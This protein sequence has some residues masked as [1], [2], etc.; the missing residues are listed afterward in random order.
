[1]RSAVVLAG[2]QSKRFQDGSGRWVDK[3]LAILSGKPLLMHVIEGVRPVV[4]E[5]IIC[6]NDATR[7]AHYLKVLENYSITNVKTCVD[8]KFSHV[9]GPSVAIATGLKESRADYCMI[10]PCDTP[11]IKPSIVDYLLKHVENI[12]ICVPIHPDGNIETLMF[13]CNR[14]KAAKIAE[15][16]CFLG[17]SKPVDIMRASSKIRFISTIN[18]LKKLDPNFQSFI[19]INFRPDLINLPTRVSKEGPVTK[20]IDLNLTQISQK[21]LDFLGKLTK[22]YYE[23]EYWDV[24]ASLSEILSALER[25][26]AHFWVGVLRET[27]GKIF[28]KLALLESKPEVAREYCVRGKVAF[29]EAARRFSLEASIYGSRQ[30]KFLFEC[31]NGDEIWCL[32]KRDE[33]TAACLK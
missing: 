7:E 2:G 12:D 1:M 29:E 18:E 8:M 23:E 16:L 25:K 10:L 19:N 3:A 15:A 33:I 30:I 13:S 27:E 6:V 5:I 31:A 22:K 28:Q 32:N 4:D 9:R 20:S 26:G 24:A 17:R 21:E 14:E 11:F